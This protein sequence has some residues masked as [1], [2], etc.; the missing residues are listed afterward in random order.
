V[1]E[2]R[3]VLRGSVTSEQQKAEIQNTAQQ[4]APGVAIENQ[5][6]VRRW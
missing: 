6:T 2:P 4:A 3:I 1:A 5:L